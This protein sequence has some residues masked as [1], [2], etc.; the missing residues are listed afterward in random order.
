[1][2]RAVSQWPRLARLVTIAAVWWIACLLGVGAAHTVLQA[3]GHHPIDTIA[4]LLERRS[5]V[6]SVGWPAAIM[7]AALLDRL[8]CQGQPK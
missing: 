1:M 8:H 2:S 5:Y 4:Y 7:M 6:I 3:L